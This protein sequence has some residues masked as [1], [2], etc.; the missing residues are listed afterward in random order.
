MEWRIPLM[1][2][3]ALIGLIISSWYSVR[4]KQDRKGE[5]GISNIEFHRLVLVLPHQETLLRADVFWYGG[6]PPSSH[7]S[8]GS[9][10]LASIPKLVGGERA[11]LFAP[12]CTGWHI[13]IR[14]SKV[15]SCLDRPFLSLSTLREEKHS[16]VCS[17][18]IWWFPSPWGL[19][20]PRKRSSST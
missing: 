19:Q 5:K 18:Q 13:L 4:L 10:D 17:L 20:R 9:L 11:L 8:S 6:K 7:K 2:R 3:K 16:M 14:P 15:V 12:W 1:C